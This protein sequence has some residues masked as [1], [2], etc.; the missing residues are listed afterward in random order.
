MFIGRKKELTVLN[1]LYAQNRFQ[2]VV[3]YGR[4]RIGKTSLINEFLKDKNSIYFTGLEENAQE[5]L[6]RFSDAIQMFQNTESMDFPTFAHF[7]Q[8]FRSIAGLAKKRRVILVIDEFPYLAQS[9]PAISSMLQSYIDH[10]FQQTNMFIILC[11]SSMSFMENQVLGYK[12]PLYGRRTA[13]MKLKPFS[14]HEAREFF[15]NMDREEVFELNTITGGIPMYLSLMS[16]DRT[17]EENI[18]ENFLQP[19]AILFEEPTNLLKQELREPSNYHSIISA[20]AGG[21][22]RQSEIVTKT[23]ITSGGINAYLKNLMDLGIIEKKVPVTEVEKPR[24]RKTIYVISDG[25]F[26][27]WYT[28]V[29][30]RISLI[31]HGITEPVLER[32]MEM[33]PDFMGSGFERL[34][35]EY[36]WDHISDTEL[37][38]EPFVHLGNWWGND[39]KAKK[40]IEMDLVG[41]DDQRINGYFGECKWKKE[42]VSKEILDTLLYRSSLFPYPKKH[43]YLFSKNGFTDECREYAQK[44]GCHLIS[45]DTM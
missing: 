8:A 36:L 22:S 3:I 37:V 6:I 18:A 15:Q 38:Q 4:R 9:Y 23:G 32:V 13:Q 28:F 1:R 35:Q 17:L 34:S 43:Y 25:M 42:A 41:Y 31:E 24:S 11:G 29:G 39:P 45:F 44:T 20:I 21:A 10:E 19:N 5:N 30:K 40:E 27:F 2:C 16:Q 7:E 33:L 12:S 14:L 26:R